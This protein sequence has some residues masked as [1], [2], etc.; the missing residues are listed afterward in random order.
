LVASDADGD[1]QRVAVARHE[2]LDVDRLV[3]DAGLDE[4]GDGR[5]LFGERTAGE[6]VFLACGHRLDLD[7]T[8][9]CEPALGR[10]DLAL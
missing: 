2:L 4:L 3:D 8:T 7:F 10:V 9:A 1:H 5:A 6:D